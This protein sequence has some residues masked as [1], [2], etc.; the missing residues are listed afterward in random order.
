M[1]DSAH[2][3]WQC[4]MAG[5]LVWEEVVK[6]V[7][8]WVQAKKKNLTGIS[9]SEEKLAFS[10]KHRPLDENKGRLRVSSNLPVKCKRMQ[11][12]VNGRNKGF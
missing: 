3:E 11:F 5:C 9:L 6:Y 12:W 7:Y 1:G 2:R 4:A 10:K 8:A